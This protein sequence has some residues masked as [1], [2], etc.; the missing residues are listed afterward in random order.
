MVAISCSIPPVM[1]ALTFPDY[2]TYCPYRF[3]WPY[4]SNYGA[5]IVK[6]AWKYSC[7]N[8]PCPQSPYC[9]SCAYA[10]YCASCYRGCYIAR[11]YCTYSPC[12]Q[13]YAYRPYFYCSNANVC[14]LYCPYGS[15]CRYL[16]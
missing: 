2:G 5:Y 10:S 3:N 6:V 13:Q 1:L 14:K 12:L 4:C 15:Y 8:I 11:K 16:G 9:S 7:R